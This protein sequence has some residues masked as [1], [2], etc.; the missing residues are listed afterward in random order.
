MVTNALPSHLGIGLYSL[1]DAARLLRI[2]PARLRRWASGPDRFLPRALDP[3]EETL[4]FAELIELQFVLLYLAEGVS[5]PV[6]KKAAAAAAEK[7]STD[8]PFSVKRFDTDGQSIF[9]TLISD[10]T[11]RRHVEDLQK[12]QYVFEKVMRPFF[13]KL[14]YQKDQLVRYWPEGKRGR[15]LLDPA[16]KFGQPIDAE[17]GVPTRAIF[18][19]LEAGE[20]QS[21][22]D[23]ARWLGIPLA[24]VKAADQFE[25]SLQ[26][27]VPVR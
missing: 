11:N 26:R 14:E 2:K 19:A 1:P 9:A 21:P 17:S 3:T 24:A 12:G 16:R 27:E 23:V 22:D 15:I 10:Q 5:L 25:R 6:I 7:F 20:G 18:S 8:H 4:T 13:H